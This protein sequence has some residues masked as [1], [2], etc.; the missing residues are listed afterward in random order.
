MF[1]LNSFTESYFKY[2][3][4]VLV[5]KNLPANAGDTGSIS[6]S[7]RSP[8]VGNGNPLQYSCLE[9]P[10][11]RGAWQA[12]VHMVKRI[13]HN[14][15]NLACNIKSHLV[16]SVKYKYSC[17]ISIKS[18]YSA[19]DVVDPLS[20]IERAFKSILKVTGSLVKYVEYSAFPR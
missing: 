17:D 20:I 18:Y 1:I 14:R 11:D 12:T 6:R 4:V 8:G 15:S 10:M 13:E 2:F 5:V 9:N 3:Q 7:G 19:Q 16:G